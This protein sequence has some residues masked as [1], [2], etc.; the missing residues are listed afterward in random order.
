MRDHPSSPLLPGDQADGRM[1]GLVAFDV[2]RSAV[3]GG[4]ASACFRRWQVCAQRR[5]TAAAGQ[6][7]DGVLF[8][9]LYDGQ[10]VGQW[11]GMLVCAPGPLP[12]DLG[13]GAPPGLPGNR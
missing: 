12:Q 5:A 4:Y 9:L 7:S 10:L 11:T 13:G 1:L 6:R 2:G 8:S 3:I